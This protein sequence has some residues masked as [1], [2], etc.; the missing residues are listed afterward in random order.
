M[1]MRVREEMRMRVNYKKK[2]FL[3]N[4]FLHFSQ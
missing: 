4:N 2:E 3:S 1:K